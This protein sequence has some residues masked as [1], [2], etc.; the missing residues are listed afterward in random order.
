MLLVYAVIFRSLIVYES[1]SSA[2]MA[3]RSMYSDVGKPSVGS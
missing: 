3:S 2:I 1:S